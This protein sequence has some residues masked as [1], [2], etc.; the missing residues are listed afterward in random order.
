MC[1]RLYGLLD[2]QVEGHGECGVPLD[3]KDLLLTRQSSEARQ[4]HDGVKGK[5]SSVPEAWAWGSKWDMS[6]WDVTVVTKEVII[7]NVLSVHLWSRTRFVAGLTAQVHS[8]HASL[9]PVHA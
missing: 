6:R 3:H 4:K 2:R 1:R 7:E 5:C 9:Q 8:V